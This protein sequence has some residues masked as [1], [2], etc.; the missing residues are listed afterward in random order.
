MQG[1]GGLDPVSTIRL[2]ETTS[3]NNPADM[4]NGFGAY[5][6]CQSGF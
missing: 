5:E 4:Q 1:G 2:I 3:Q 6:D